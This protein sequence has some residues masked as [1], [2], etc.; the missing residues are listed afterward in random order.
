M[1]TP[2]TPTRGTAGL[3]TM[4]CRW[5]VTLVAALLLASTAHAQ[6]AKKSAAKKRK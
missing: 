4:S 6:E 3:S 1:M 5:L 2:F